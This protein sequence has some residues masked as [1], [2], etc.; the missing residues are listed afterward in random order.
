MRIGID[1]GG[2]FTDVV[3]VDDGTGQIYYAKT[4]TT[5]GSLADGVLAGIEKGLALAGTSIDELTYIAHGTTIGTNA[6]IERTG[7]RTGLITT[8]GFVDVLEIGRCQRPRE[9]MY[10]LSVDMPPP[11]VPR[12]LRRPVR[13]RID[14]DGTVVIPLDE[15]TAEAAVDRLR[16]RGVEAIA[17][18]LLWAFV[19]PVHERRIAEIIA[20]RFP[21]IP[22]SL[23]SSIAPEFREFERTS[24]TVL[25]AYLEPVTVAYLDSLSG[26]LARQYG[27]ELDVRIMQASG[28]SMTIRDA[29]ERAVNMVNSGPAGGVIAASFIGQLTGFEQIIGVDMGGTSFDIAVIDRGRPPVSSERSFCGYPVRIPVID[30]DSIGAGG[31]S[32][33]WV[34]AGG[35][36]NVGPRSAGAQPGPASYGRGGERPTVTDA[37]LVL[38]RLNPKYFLGGEMSLDVDA[39]RQ[40]IRQHVGKPLGLSVEDAAAGIVRI[41]NATMAKGIAVNSIERGHD[42]REF[43]LVAFGGAGALHAADLADEMSIGTVIVPAL[44]GNLS[45]LGLLVS[46]ARHDLVQTYGRLAAES[47]PAEL[48]RRFKDLEAQA[49][50]RLSRDGF[51]P[52]RRQV[53]WTVDARYEG[54][55]YEINVPVA[56]DLDLVALARA[57]NTL[58]QRL[59]TYSSPSENVQLVNLRVTGI[60]RVPPVRLGQLERGPAGGWPPAA[61][62]PKAHRSIFFF[63]RGFV[64]APVYE[65]AHLPAGA[66]IAGPCLVEE[67][68]AGT[69]ITEGWIAR[70]DQYGNLI[71][72][73]R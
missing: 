62:S 13:E 16:E 19:N 29:R 32:I 25:N 8:E 39:A 35:A 57:F 60:G 55:S 67:V 65:R 66:A 41:I 2:T 11:L 72:T 37:N 52:D 27:R 61:A 7:A 21:G 1:V 17:V 26:R 49:F 3:V 48:S 71:L 68:I 18:S 12:D 4:S 24:T 30:I 28:G 20:R 69:V 15:S 73:R 53:L 23:S 63:G 56:N 33:A 70:A 51:P 14:R 59:Y 64:E 10:D 46:D 36:L 47:D 44:S 54:Q 58:H 42:V 31:G 5:P 45:A 34:D 22:V 43:V 40:A 38:G 50:E 9:G 6:L